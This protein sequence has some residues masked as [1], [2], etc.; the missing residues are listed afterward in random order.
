MSIWSSVP[1]E[2]VKALNG[3]HENANYRAEG[4]RTLE[5]DVAT[6][7]SW[8]DHIRLAIWGDGEDVDALL[9]PDGARLLA[10]QLE[11][12]AAWADGTAS[13]EKR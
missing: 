4:E 1:G 12:A 13:P 10:K 11:A 7:T 3:A 6:A 5:V 8:H 2:T 9:S